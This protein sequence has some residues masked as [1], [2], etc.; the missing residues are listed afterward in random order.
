MKTVIIIIAA[1]VISITANFLI[2]GDT[3]KTA[4][5]NKRI[6][7]IETKIDSIDDRVCKLQIVA[8]SIKSDTKEIKTE[9]QTINSKIDTIKAVVKEIKNTTNNIEFKLF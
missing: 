2:G 8:D 1:V 6:N 3:V 5:F 4:H 9:V 7:Q